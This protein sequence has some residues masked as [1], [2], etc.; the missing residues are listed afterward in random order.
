VGFRRGIGASWRPVA[1]PLLVWLLLTLAGAGGL[2]CQQHNSREALAQRFQLR[3]GLIGDFVTS[4]TTDLIARERVQA[5]SSLA[6]PSVSARDF[7]RAVAGFGYPAAVLLDNRGRALQV[8]PGDPSVIG[9]NLADR[10]V[11]LR[12]AL[13]LGR[14]AVSPVVLSAAQGIPVVAFAVPFATSSG[15]RVFSGA[16]DIKRSPLTSYLST[17]LNFS[18]AQVQLVDAAGSIVASNRPSPEAIPTLAGESSALAGALHAKE[19][20]RYRA[21]GRWWRYSSTP[22][23]GTPWRLSATVTEDVLFASLAGNEKAGYAALGGAAAVGLLVVAAAGR[24]RRNRRDLQLSEYRFRRVFDGSRIGMTLTDTEGRFLRVNPAASDMFGRTEEDLIGTLFA[25]VTHPDDRKAARELAQDCLAGR[26]DGFDLDKRYLR[27]D[28]A[29]IDASI[30]SALL[31]DREGHPQYFTTQI[32]DVTERRALERVRRE[33]ETELAQRAEQLQEANS[34][35][36]DFMA[37]LSHDVRQPLANIVGLGEL[38]A[39]DWSEM[40]DAARLSDVR[41]MTAAGHRAGDLVT[42]ILTLARLDA[43]ALVARAA[44]I[45]ISHAV[46]EGVAAYCSS[47]PASI[48]VVAPDQTTGLADPAH[49]QLILGNLLANATKYGRPPFAVTVSNRGEQIMIEVT[50]H[51]EGVPDEFVPHLFERFSRADTGVATTAAGTGL[52]L[53]LVRQLANAGGLSIAYQP[54]RPSGAT[55]VIA[56]PCATSRTGGVSYP[57]TAPTHQP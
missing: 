34:H 54:T 16:V 6:D 26:A 24:A 3:V 25:E 28:G 46:R 32:V 10:Y 57:R 11:H 55:F 53:Y 21:G 38:L 45:D 27:S 39:D 36:A 23:A 4:Y 31:R 9:T 56:V 37:M 30:T 18:G 41:R 15:R 2:V 52:G 49:L 40:P 42:D 29:T 43:G 14:P 35:L 8:I 44:R 12:T 33:H 51:G 5:D 19:Q 1:V 13:R 20:G 48:S 7:A 47:H 17:A 22:I 50:D